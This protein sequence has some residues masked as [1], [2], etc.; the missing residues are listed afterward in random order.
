MQPLFSKMIEESLRATG[1]MPQVAGIFTGTGTAESKSA[2]IFRW[3]GGTWLVQYDRHHVGN[4]ADSKGMKYINRLLGSPHTDLHVLDLYLHVHRTPPMSDNPYHSM[5]AVEL[6]EELL[7]VKKLNTAI[8]EDYD[9]QGFFDALDIVKDLEE[10]IKEAKQEQTS[11]EKIKRLERDR[12]IAMDYIGAKYDN[13]GR[14]RAESDQFKVTV[15]PPPHFN[16]AIDGP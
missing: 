10:Q 2:N 14:D 9:M 12:I 15:Q 8:H 4:F 16:F 6:E 3:N 5:S 7:T 1:R 11:S 13:K